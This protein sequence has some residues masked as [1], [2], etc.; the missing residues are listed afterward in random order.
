MAGNFRC[1]VSVSSAKIRTRLLC[2]LNQSA[3]WKY[4][5]CSLHVLSWRRRFKS[6]WICTWCVADIIWLFHIEDLGQFTVLHNVGLVQSRLWCSRSL[7]DYSSSFKLW[8]GPNWNGTDNQVK[9]WSEN[10]VNYNFFLWENKCPTNCTNDTHLKCTS[11]QIL[12]FF[13]N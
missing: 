7:L 10:N 11:A 3:D 13:C 9:I 6:L 1:S 5:G 4:S 12:I 2:S 8:V